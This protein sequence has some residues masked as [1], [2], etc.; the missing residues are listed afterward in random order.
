[1]ADYQERLADR[2]RYEMERQSIS[3]DELALRSGVSGKTI[4]RI[5]DKTI[6][7]PR[8][9]TLRRLA[10]GLKIEPEI[11]S[12][13]EELDAVQLER[14]EE[15]IDDA[16]GMLRRLVEDGE[17]E[18]VEQLAGEAAVEVAPPAGQRR[19]KPDVASG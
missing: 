8:P 4:K 14:L 12:P 17:A 7:R 13:P 10:V 3:R 19:R 18:E 9:V 16:L 11:L 5:E 1:M 2:L 15:K 6:K